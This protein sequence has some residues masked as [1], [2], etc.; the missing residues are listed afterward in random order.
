MGKR[1]VLKFSSGRCLSSAGPARM[2][3]YPD[4][5]KHVSD[6]KRAQTELLIEHPNHFHNYPHLNSPVTDE[7]LVGGDC[8]MMLSTQH[9]GALS[10]WHCEEVQSR[11]SMRKV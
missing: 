5:G 3:A 10:K 2:R 6:P 8:A 11:E 1:Q 4:S 7:E 9:F